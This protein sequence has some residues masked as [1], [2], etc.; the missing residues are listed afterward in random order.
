MSETIICPICKSQYQEKMSACTKCNFPFSASEKEKAIFIGQQLV[1]KSR[2][3]G[4]K[5]KIRRARNILWIMSVA[6][7]VFIIISTNSE[8][9]LIL[10]AILSLIF[11]GF[12]F[13]TYKKPFISIFIPLSLLLLSYIVTGIIEP[14]FLINGIIWRIVFISG[15]SYALL[16]IVE[17]NKIKKE[18]AYLMEQKY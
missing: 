4:T 15:L 10:S 2:I 11:I 5:D 1:K 18:N 13:L 17:A 6:N 7:F 9:V 3:S 16:G 14:S 12:G 8:Q